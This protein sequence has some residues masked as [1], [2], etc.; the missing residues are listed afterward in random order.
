MREYVIKILAASFAACIAEMLLPEKSMKKFAMS[1]IGVG[2]VA[3]IA[4]PAL[5]LLK[6][7]LNFDDIFPEEEVF[8]Y[9]STYNEE[10]AAE[11]KN[12]I[13]KSIEEKGEVT[14]EV[15]L[16]ENMEIE[17]V[18][19]TGNVDSKVLYYVNVDLGVTRDAI[20]TE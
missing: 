10:I 16:N 20:R 3:V 6:T 5:N 2:I 4:L 17:S 15:T 8:S 18:K 14:A 12:R 9:E 11:Y 19:L 1:I 7:D 13:E